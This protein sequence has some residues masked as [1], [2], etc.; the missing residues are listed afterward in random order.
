MQCHFAYFLE[1]IE[2]SQRSLGLSTCHEEV[3]RAAFAVDN[4]VDFGAAVTT[5][6]EQLRLPWVLVV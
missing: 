2:C 1:S 6:D 4:R 3:Q 5:A